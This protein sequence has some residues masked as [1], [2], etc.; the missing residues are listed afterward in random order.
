MD[1]KRIHLRFFS[2][3][4][5]SLFCEGILLSL[6]VI[7]VLLVVIL[8]LLVLVLVLILLVL[9]LILI[10]ILIVLHHNILVFCIAFPRI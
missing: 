3:C 4:I 6:V 1:S 10:L 5:P 9:A 7:L 8:V 2:I